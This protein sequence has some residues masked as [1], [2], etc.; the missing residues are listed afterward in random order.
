[1]RVRL[2]VSVKTSDEWM[3]RV[4]AVALHKSS[5][6]WVRAVTQMFGPC[7]QEILVALTSA[8]RAAVTTSDLRRING[9]TPRYHSLTRSGRWTSTTHL[10]RT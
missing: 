3:R 8:R 6:L 10:L 1:M 7:K 4:Q 2:I 9:P 5:V